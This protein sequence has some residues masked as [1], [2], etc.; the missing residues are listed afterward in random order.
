MNPGGTE[1][2]SSMAW[3]P[4]PDSVNSVLEGVEFGMT[5]GKTTR[6]CFISQHELDKWA[7]HQGK[8]DRNV[9][10][11][12]FRKHATEIYAATARVLDTK[13]FAALTTL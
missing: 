3:K 7:N 2:I 5:N 8:I 4:V 1:D 13:P 11:Q 12:I 10:L 6:A 9:A